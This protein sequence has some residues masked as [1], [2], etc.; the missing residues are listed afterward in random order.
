MIAKILIVEDNITFI[1]AVRSSIKGDKRKVIVAMSVVEAIKA[2]K[3]HDG[4]FDCVILDRNLPDGKGE[5]LAQ[6]L[7]RINPRLEIIFA[8]SDMSQETLTSMLEVGCSSF[9]AKGKDGLAIRQAINTAISR[10]Q[11]TRMLLRPLDLEDL[12][13]GERALR[14]INIVSR[15]PVMIENCERIKN[16]RNENVDCLILGET[17]SG[18]ELVARAIADGRGPLVSINCANYRTEDN[19]AQRDFFGSLKSAFTGAV[20]QTG[21]FETAKGGT[22]FIDE[23]D[24]LHPSA[25]GILLKVIEDR[26]FKKMGDTSGREIPVQCRII[27]GGKIELSELVDKKVFL[28]DLY[29]RIWRSKIIVPPLRDRHCDIEPLVRHF[30]GVFAARHN[31]KVYFRSDTLPVLSALPWPGNIRGLQNLVSDMVREAKQEIITAEHLVAFL[32]GEAAAKGSK[33]LPVDVLDLK[34]LSKS[35]DATHIKSILRLSKTAV[36]AAERLGV[37]RS[38]LYDRCKKLGFKPEGYL[39]KPV[40]ENV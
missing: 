32:Q 35:F 30:T 38:T 18:K 29:H 16:I 8:T 15:H 13:H 7:K 5:D 20:D 27:Y 14:A 34:I 17:G 10:F 33:P 37:A 21:F 11:S 36:E 2:F 3:E 9:L 24:K 25:Q 28:E 12:E 39:N 22:I 4:E 31:K 1:D 23:I 26:R 6:T 19:F 40:E